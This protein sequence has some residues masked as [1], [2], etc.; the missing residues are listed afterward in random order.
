MRKLR[1]DCI[2]FFIL[3]FIVQWCAHTRDALTRENFRF[4]AEFI[5]A[6]TREIFTNMTKKRPN[7]YF[8]LISIIL[9]LSIDLN[10]PFEF[11]RLNLH[12]KISPFCQVGQFRHLARWGNFATLPHRGNFATLLVIL[13]VSINTA[14]PFDWL[15][16]P[17]LVLLMGNC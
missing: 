1:L 8:H 11:F 5:R 17:P 13:A 10:S 9:R 2:C 16:S 14:R 3:V 7:E 4:L 6:H 15:T 12:G